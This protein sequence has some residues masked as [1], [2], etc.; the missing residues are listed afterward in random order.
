MKV[1]FDIENIDELESYLLKHSNRDSLRESLIAE[2]L[3]DAYYKNVRQWNRAVRIC[4]CLAIIGWGEYEPLEALRGKWFNGNPQTC[5]LN[6]FGDLRFVE[7]IWSK[8]K[9]GFTMEQGRTSFHYSPDDINNIQTILSEYPTKEDIQSLSLN[10]QRNW[11]PKNPIWIT[12]GVSNCYE[13]SKE[14]IDSLSKELQVELNERM[15]PEK[16]GRKVNRLIL[17]CAFSF[18]DNDHCKTNYIIS[19]SNKPLTNSKAWEEIRKTF[20]EKEIE[21]NGYYLRNRYKFGPFRKD[22]GN[23]QITIHFE[24]EFSDLSHLEQKKVLSE[25]FKQAIIQTA[26]KLKKKDLGYDFD[27]MIGDF[28]RVLS[29]WSVGNTANT[30]L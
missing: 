12:R 17:S 5:F 9:S 24:K 4:E 28:T 11:I 6:K 20:S 7:A 15:R 1:V 25:Y 10:S 27:A 22:T 18:F 26:E 30:S 2:F 13:N 8:R 29:S 19:E 3:R 16:Y 21:D 14:L 23:V